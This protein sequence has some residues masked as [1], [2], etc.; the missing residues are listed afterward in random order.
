MVQEIKRN[1]VVFDL[2]CSYKEKGDNSDCYE[3][4]R[5]HRLTG[6]RLLHDSQ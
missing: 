5:P 6:H 1:K 4:V 2:H 3:K